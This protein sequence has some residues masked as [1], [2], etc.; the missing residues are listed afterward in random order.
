MRG[1]RSW[2]VVSRRRADDDGA[3]QQLDRERGENRA[4]FVHTTLMGEIRRANEQLLCALTRVPF[5][6]FAIAFEKEEL[7]E[8][9]AVPLQVEV[10]AAAE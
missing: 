4:Y 10:Q 9:V 3:A 5:F 1:E 8:A 7:A 6:E 2:G